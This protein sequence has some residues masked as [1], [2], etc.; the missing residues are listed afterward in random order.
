L[1]QREL[2]PKWHSIGSAVFAYTAAKTSEVFFQW[3]GQPSRLPL[4]GCN[5]ALRLPERK[6]D[7]QQRQQQQGAALMGR[8]I[9]GPP[10]AAPW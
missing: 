2:D 6:N 9:T 10:R 7:R 1:G 8:N 5:L 4:P 3:G